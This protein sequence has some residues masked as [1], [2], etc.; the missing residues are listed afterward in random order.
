MELLKD[1]SV[2]F[3][4]NSDK[5]RMELTENMILRERLFDKDDEIEKEERASRP[6]QRRPYRKYR[7]ENDPSMPEVNTR[8]LRSDI[9]RDSESC[10]Q[11]PKS[12]EEGAVS[13]GEP[14][15][16][17]PTVA[18]ET[19]NQNVISDVTRENVGAVSAVRIRTKDEPTVRTAL[20]S[21]NR[22]QWIASM[23]KELDQMF[24][25]RDVLLPTEYSR[26]GLRPDGEYDLIG[27]TMQLK[28][29]RTADGNIDKF[30][31][32]LCALG[33]QFS[34]DREI[35]TYSPTVDNLV[36]M[37]TLQIA[38]IDQMIRRGADTVGAYLYQK[39]TG[40]PLYV[41]LDGPMAAAVGLD[42]STLYRVNRYIY[43]LPES[44]L[45]YYLAYSEWLMSEKYV[46]SVSDPCLFIKVNDESRTYIWIHV[47]DTFIVSTSQEQI[48]LFFELLNARWKVTWDEDI[49]SYLGINFENLGPEGGVR[50]TQP[51]LLNSIFE[52]FGEAAS[53]HHASAPMRLNKP[54]IKDSPR[55][56][57][58]DYL[59]L[60]GSLTYLLKS[61]PDMSLAISWAASKSQNPTE[62]DYDDLLYMVSWLKKTRELGLILMPGRVND[63]L[64][65]TCYVDASYLLYDDSKS[66]TGYTVSFGSLA[67]C[68]TARSVKQSTVATSSMHAETIAAFTL[69]KTIVFL[70]HLCMEL[71]R[72][73]E[74]PAIILED[75]QALRKVAG[76]G[77][78]PTKRARHFLM[79]VNYLRE[80]VM[81]GLIVWK[82]IPAHLNIADILT[83]VVVGQ[84]FFYKAQ[85]ILGTA[86]GVERLEPALSKRKTD[87]RQRLASRVKERRGQ[88]DVIVAFSTDTKASDGGR[89]VRRK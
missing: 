36:Y 50:L 43:G 72:P 52:E 81:R 65:L 7:P 25:E 85:G 89:R 38:V 47:D 10:Q 27:T 62:S 48:D 78:G 77:F 66:Q 49:S 30:K 13:E 8:C 61:R 88:R 82:E 21:E 63:P 23:K 67:G 57:A 59:H 32:R 26:Y 58:T 41:Y 45:Q 29:K 16:G 11:E 22:E 39:Y 79:M 37:A 64:T 86:P 19:V 55:V 68:F 84:D 75:N 35:P 14:E 80:M 28:L 4:S 5:D 33:N 40:K 69:V 73:F 83:K 6:V 42:P 51:K 71:H 60:L 3:A 20:R 53:K 17:E 87:R 34:S 44:G 1:Y 54:V 24:R 76:S 56:N 15:K 2:S 70:Y 74:L 46:R 9:A 12:P 18:V 31:A